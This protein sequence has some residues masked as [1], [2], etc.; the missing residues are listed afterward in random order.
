MSYIDR[1]LNGTWKPQP[2]AEYVEERIKEHPE[3][4]QSFRE[5][6]QHFK[7]ADKHER[8]ENR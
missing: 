8:F 5:A 1:I 7:E 6:A 3:W 4:E 2:F